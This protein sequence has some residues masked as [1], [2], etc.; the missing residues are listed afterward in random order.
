MLIVGH[1]VGQIEAAFFTAT[2]MLPHIL[3]HKT[4]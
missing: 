4:G 1:S 3:P 2:N